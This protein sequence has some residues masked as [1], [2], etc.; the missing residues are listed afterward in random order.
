MINLKRITNYLYTST[1]R[2][3]AGRRLEHLERVGE[4]TG[5]YPDRLEEMAEDLEE[6]AAHTQR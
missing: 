2:L 4:A 3:P 6:A 1:S 5:A